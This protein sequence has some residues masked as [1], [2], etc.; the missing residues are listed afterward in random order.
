MPQ[1]MTRTG[2]AALT[3]PGISSPQAMAPVSPPS[4]CR[5]SNIM[6]GEPTVVQGHT[7]K[8][9]HHLEQQLSGQLVWDAAIVPVRR[10]R[11]QCPAAD[12]GPLIGRDAALDVQRNG[13]PRSDIAADPRGI[14]GHVDE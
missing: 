6:P 11:R 9:R 5:S 8:E 12:L 3:S 14:T 10:D 13:D 2:E 1:P 7:A 4:N